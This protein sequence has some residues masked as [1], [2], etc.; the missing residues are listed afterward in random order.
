MYW[1]KR[2]FSVLVAGALSAVAGCGGASSDLSQPVAGAP[3]A[4][5]AAYV[6]PKAT[7]GAG[8]H[9]E[10]ALQGQVP[11]FMRNGFGGFNCNLEVIG[12]FQGEGSDWSAAMYTDAAGH[13]CAYHAMAA[14]T[15]GNGK[16]RAI[17]NPGVPVIDITDPTKPVRVTSLTSA[18]MLDPWESLRVSMKR[19]LLVADNGSNG[20]GGAQVD[21]YDIASDCRHP[22]LLSSIDVGTGSDGGVVAPKA[23]SGHEGGLSPDGLTYYI[24]SL[25]SNAYYAIDIS[26][27]EHPKNIASVDLATLPL[28]GLAH[29]LSVSDDGNRAY[30]ASIGADAIGLASLPPPLNDPNAKVQNGFYIMDTTQVQARSPKAQMTLVAAVPVRDGSTSQHT[31]P[32]RI[33]G[34]PYL[35]HVDEGGAGGLLDPATK[36][37]AA[38]CAAGLAPFPMAHIYDMSNE[39]SPVQISETRLETHVIANCSK[40]LPDMVGVNIFGYGSHYCT[41]DNRDNATAMACGFQDSGVRVF[42]IRDP[43]A[44]KE[45]AYLNPPGTT[46]SVPGSQHTYRGW[47]PGN[48]D[49]CNARLD[50]DFA[51]HRLVTACQDNGELV[52]AFKNGVW[53]M[54]ESTPATDASN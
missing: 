35:V 15:D 19:G 17:V 38:A 7:C 10:T 1:L 47:H 51:N 31:I 4:A 40:V 27:P 3:S 8:D 34:K 30:F 42:D 33:K 12:Q 46:V 23:P 6:V 16:S 22:Q 45:I 21:I 28:G 18:A 39:A 49:W 26:V 20:G 36:N 9:P 11:A 44:P 52:M 48:P 13:V 53:P 37:A 2:L 41:V 50:F 43:A 25:L 24:G 5:V 14:P 54:P 29:G 32:I